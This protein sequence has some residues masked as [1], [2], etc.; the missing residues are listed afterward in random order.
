MKCN[1]LVLCNSFAHGGGEKI[2]AN[3]ANGLHENGESVNAFIIEDK[4]SYEVNNAIKIYSLPFKIKFFNDIAAFFYLIYVIKANKIDKVISHLFRAN[5]LNVFASFFT[6]HKSIVATHGSI[7]KYKNGKISS[8]INLFLID[9][10]FKKASKKVF[11]TERMKDDYI[12]YVGAENNVV[13]PN[14][15][16]FDEIHIKAQVV[17]N[18]NPF[19]ENEYFIFVGRFHPVKRIDLIL[20][21][22]S[23]LNKKLLLVGDGELY[24]QLR[25]AYEADNIVF[26]GNKKNPYP[27]IKGAKA[28]ILASESEGFPNV[29]VEALALGVP[30]ISSDCRTGPREILGVSGKIVIEDYYVN[31]KSGLFKVNDA[32]SL[33]ELILLFDRTHKKTGII[34]NGILRFNI[35][36]VVAEYAR[37]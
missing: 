12:P 32:S 6:G 29:I 37:L 25:E 31:D 24:D 17:Q 34:E 9:F 15:Y 4:I 18:D 26:L 19:K 28:I 20:Q 23:A 16:D 3:I 36:Q 35:N 5:Y 2:A 10:L 7:S 14:C 27:Y 11:L 22:I 30:V 21:V 8:K 1:Y 33:S 13:I